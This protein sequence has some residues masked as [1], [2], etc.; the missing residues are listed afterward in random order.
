LVFHQLL[1]KVARITPSPLLKIP[2]APWFVGP[3]CCF[4][5]LLSGGLKKIGPRARH[6]AG[7]EP[8]PRGPREIIST[9]AL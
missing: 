1:K 6:V 5:Y 8:N 2:G 4:G 7:H 3:R 9:K